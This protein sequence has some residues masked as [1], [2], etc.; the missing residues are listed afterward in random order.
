MKS[1]PLLVGFSLACTMALAADGAQDAKREPTNP[2][3]GPLNIPGSPRITIAG[4]ES[5]SPFTVAHPFEQDRYR[6]LYYSY[7]HGT[8]NQVNEPE[9]A[10][11]PSATD[12]QGRPLWFDGENGEDSLRQLVSGLFD[13]GKLDDLNKLFEDW[14]NPAERM[15]DGRWKLMAFYKALGETFSNSPHWDRLQTYIQDWRRKAPKSRAAALAEVIYWNAYAWNARGS[16]YASSV[17]QEG[18]DLFRERLKK[19]EATLRESKSYASS[20]PLW[21]RLYIDVATG[22]QWPAPKLLQIFNEATATRKYFYPVYSSM[23]ASLSPR[24][25]GNWQLVDSFVKQ[26][27]RDTPD[28]GASMYAR[29]YWGISQNEVPSFSLFRDSLATW[30][31]MKRGFEDLVRLYPHSAY[32]LNNFAAAA[33]MADDKTTF[34]SLRFRIGKNVTPESWPSNYSL[35]LCEHKLALQSL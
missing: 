10:T 25:G 14:N 24:W 3:D 2:F 1:L 21:G 12:Q 29:L 4:E 15:A 32:N 9:L 5:A 30:P 26:A 16:G 35:D 34:Q 17:T 6:G 13:W 20:S 23:V 11:L 27:V 7:Y 28:E 18:W 22:L 31:E 33:C 8:F 19:A